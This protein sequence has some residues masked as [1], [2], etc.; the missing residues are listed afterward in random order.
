MDNLDSIFYS[1]RNN[2]D[3]PCKFCHSIFDHA[4]WCATQNSTV[5]YAYQIVAESAQ[6][7]EGDSLVLH[8]LGV[9]WEPSQT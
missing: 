4:Q 5:L 7:T 6:L 3:S 1:K 8:S 2:P 9:A